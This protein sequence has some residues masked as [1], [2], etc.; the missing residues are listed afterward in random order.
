[1]SMWRQQKI[2]QISIFSWFATDKHKLTLN[3]I[4]TYFHFINLTLEIW[5]D[6]NRYRRSKQLLCL[7]RSVLSVYAYIRVFMRSCNY[8][9]VACK[10]FWMLLAALFFFAIRCVRVCIISLD[11]VFVVIFI[12]SFVVL[13]HENLIQ[14]QLFLEEMF[15]LNYFLVA[16]IL[17]NIDAQ[18]ELIGMRN[19]LN[20]LN[21]ELVC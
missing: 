2:A 9:F 15:L 17:M 11:L 20:K 10:I 1:M 8:Y 5:H 21:F 16:N 18:Y 4:T 14:S 3:W 13:Y 19:S 7:L 12:C 6:L